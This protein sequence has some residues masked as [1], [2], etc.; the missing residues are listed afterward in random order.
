MNRRQ[1]VRRKRAK[2]G[3][4]TSIGPMVCGGE[5]TSIP[6][7]TM[8]CAGVATTGNTWM[9][10]A[11][12]YSLALTIV[13]IAAWLGVCGCESSVESGKVRWVIERVVMLG[14]WYGWPE[15]FSY[16][17]KS[18]TLRVGGKTGFLF[19]VQGPRSAGCAKHFEAICWLSSRRHS[20]DWYMPFPLATLFHWNWKWYAFT[21]SPEYFSSK[22]FRFVV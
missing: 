5:G 6:W 7:C 18:F 10:I 2:L 14:A 13:P 3:G 20:L 9:V 11:A 8:C 19:C 16:I 21:P 12:W 4:L 17:G 15:M 1:Q 22:S